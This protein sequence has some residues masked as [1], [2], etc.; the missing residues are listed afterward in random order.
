MKKT[1]PA[2]ELA[3]IDVFLDTLW[4]ERGVSPNTVAA[5]R[6]DLTRCARWLHE[7]GERLLTA[8]RHHLSHYLSDQAGDRRARSR[9]IARRLSC[10]RRFYQ[11][12]VREGRREDDPTAQ[13][14]APKLPQTLP[15]V[16]SESEVEALLLAPDTEATLGLRDRAM[17]ELL[18]ACGLRVSELVGLP[19]VRVSR[20]QAVVRVMG[21]GG[22]ERLVPMGEEAAQWLE[23]YLDGARPQLLRG[24]MSDALFV[25]QRGAAM[26]RQAFWYLIKRYARSVAIR[27]PLSPHTLRHSFATHLVNHGADL[28]AVQ[29]LL[30][31]ADLSTTQIYTH[32]AKERLKQLHARHHPR[33]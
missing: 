28:R 4:M 23:R 12:L 27:V 3:L 29:L 2:P 33:A 16:L 7:R 24:R 9:T 14:D 11:Y 30:G 18:Y 10:L 8:T 1:V 19:L 31:H 20:S 15:S 13:V 25:T 32:V 17:L 26:T 22:R 6:S 21:K 5:Y